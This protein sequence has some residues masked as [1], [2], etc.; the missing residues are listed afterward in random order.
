MRVKESSNRSSSGTVIVD[1]LDIDTSKIT[2]SK[3]KPNKYNGRQ[4]RIL[5]GGKTL[6]VKYK[7]T[8]PFG[9]VEN[10]DKE[11]KSGILSAVLPA[12]IAVA[13]AIGQTLGLSALAGAASEGASQIIKKISGGQLPVGQIFRV[14][15][16]K[17]FMLAKMSNLLTQKQKRDLAAA[18]Q[19]MSDMNLR[20]TGKQVGNGVGALLASIG[21]P[22]AIEAVKKIN[23]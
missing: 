12:L 15:N 22:L 20:V 21:I 9:L 3:P 17:L 18:H 8:T 19:M 1:F 14:P 10:F 4:I 6:F 23:R 5:Y 7:G 2:F 13:P 11:G 16:D